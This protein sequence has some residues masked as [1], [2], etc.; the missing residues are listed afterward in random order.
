MTGTDLARRL[1]G[2]VAG[3]KL[4]V[5]SGFAED[6]GIAEDLPRLT[7]PFRQSELAAKLAGLAEA[8]A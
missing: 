2:S 1:R 7:K 5:I 3:A 6:E 4:L 8:S